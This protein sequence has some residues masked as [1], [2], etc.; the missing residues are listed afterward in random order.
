MMKFKLRKIFSCI[1]KYIHVKRVGEKG[2][3]VVWDLSIS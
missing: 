1:V 2:R 3:K